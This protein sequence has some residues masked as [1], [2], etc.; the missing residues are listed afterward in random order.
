M[1]ILR[2]LIKLF[3]KTTEQFPT[4]VNIIEEREYNIYDEQ[5]GVNYTIHWRKK[6]KF[7]NK[8]TKWHVHTDLYDDIMEFDSLDEAKAHVKERII[9]TKQYSNN[10]MPEYYEKAQFK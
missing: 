7:M 6:H 3:G 5:I 1:N 2:K 10:Y 9:S 8:Y 4:Q